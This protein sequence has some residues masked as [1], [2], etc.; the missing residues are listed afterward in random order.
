MVDT[1]PRPPAPP[2]RNKSTKDEA[3]RALLS[4]TNNPK[5]DLTLDTEGHRLVYYCVDMPLPNEAQDARYNAKNIAHFEKR[6]LDSLEEAHKSIEAV[7]NLR[8]VK[9]PYVYGGR[10]PDIAYLNLSH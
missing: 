8:F 3:I 1:A 6:H 10:M 7:S 5:L 9:M 2:S 4:D